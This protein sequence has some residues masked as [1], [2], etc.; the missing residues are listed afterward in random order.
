VNQQGIAAPSD[1]L[2][3]R[4]GR[5]EAKV[6]KIGLGYRLKKKSV[7]IPNLI[8]KPANYGRGSVLPQGK[9]APPRTLPRPLSCWIPNRVWNDEQKA[10]RPIAGEYV[11]PRAKYRIIPHHP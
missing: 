4:E 2:V 9:L 8:W 5:E 11:A 3:S 10:V 6:A 1:W 7:V